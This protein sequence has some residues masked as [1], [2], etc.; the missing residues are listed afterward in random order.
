MKI[1]TTRTFSNGITRAGVLK[2]EKILTTNDTVEGEAI[3]ENDIPI[4]YPDHKVISA[5]SGWERGRLNYLMPPNVM[6]GEYRNGSPEYAGTQNFMP[7]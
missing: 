6:I 7:V 1:K 3:L 4:E 2:I 5:Y